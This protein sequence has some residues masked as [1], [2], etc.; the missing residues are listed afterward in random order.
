MLADLLFGD[1]LAAHELLELLDVFVAVVSDAKT[2]ASV[3]ACTAGLLV[4][5]FDALGDVV[6]DDETDVG[7][8]DTHA[9]RDGGHYHVDVFHQELVLVLGTDLGVEPCVVR[10]GLDAVDLK[11]LR[12][13]LH[14]AAAQAVDYARLAG[15]LADE[16]DYVLVGV[17]LVADFV[18][19]VRAVERRLVDDRL[20][21]SEGLEDVALHLG[22][23]GG[24]KG[25]DR[26][27]ADSIHD[28]TDAAVLRP[29]VVS[30]F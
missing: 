15:M 2:L 13:L 27:P 30:P 28:G 23:G 6:V 24:S 9:E 14:L 1:G 3:T 11:E 19:E 8:V 16:A 25:Y 29:E 12:H 22:G 18:V 17:D 26:S 7:L 10:K 4:V 21:D 20:G 5:T